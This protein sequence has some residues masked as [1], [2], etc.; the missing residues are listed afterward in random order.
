MY[1]RMRTERKIISTLLV[2]ILLSTLAGCEKYLSQVPDMRTDLD[3]IEKIQSLLGSAYS[4]GNYATILESATD[5][6][7]DKGPNA[8]S[9]QH[10]EVNRGPYMFEDVGSEVNQDSPNYFWNN[11]WRAIAAANH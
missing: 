3:K 11:T 2:V 5:N 6:V 4:V 7:D 10:Y 9:A 8:V 1:C